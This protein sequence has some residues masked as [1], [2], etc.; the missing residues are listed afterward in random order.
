MEQLLALYTELV[1]GA[2]DDK[3]VEHLTNLVT[4]AAALSEAI[5]NIVDQARART[6][7]PTQ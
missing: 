1:R 4:D 3:I 7:Q 2:T 6:G 5:K